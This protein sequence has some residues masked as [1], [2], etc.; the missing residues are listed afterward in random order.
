MVNG[1]DGSDF[2]RT[3]SLGET[4]NGLG[5]DDTIN[6]LAGDDI[7][8]GGSGFD[9]LAGG[10][11]NDQLFGE[12]GE[13]LLKGEDGDDLLVGGIGRDVQIGGAGQDTF[14]FNKTNESR[15]GANHDL[16]KQFKHSE[17][18]KID[19]QT[20]DADTTAGGNQAFD[21]IGG[22]VFSG[23]AGEL[24]L[25]GG[26]LTGDTNGDGIA[27][28]EIKVTGIGAARRA[29]SSSKRPASAYAGEAGAKALPPPVLP[30]QEPG[31]APGSMTSRAGRDSPHPDPLFV[32]PTKAGIHCSA[33]DMATS[34]QWTPA[35]ACGDEN[36]K[37]NSFTTL[38]CS[39]G[40]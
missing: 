33:S 25:A 30:A 5:G 39:P 24:R 11:G 18:D 9:Q 38:I 13:D 21:F 12:G 8:R 36:G 29:T 6:G 3:F 28:F 23:T 37:R 22:A 20:I 15:V 26:F 40:L 4:I 32:I 14:D 16:I 35:F 10:A 7:I 17:N 1:T 27:N 31:H 19:L 2:I 34:E